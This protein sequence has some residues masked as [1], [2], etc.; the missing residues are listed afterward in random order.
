VHLLSRRRRYG[1]SVLR[2][3]A[4]VA[5]Y[6]APLIENVQLVERLALGVATQ[7]RRRI[8]RDLHD[9]TV[10]PYIG[11][12]LGLEALRRRLPAGS[13]VASE[14]DELVR[15]AGDGISHLREYVDSL[16]QPGTK[17]GPKPLVEAI[18]EQV[19]RFSE[20]HKIEV[21]L[22]AEED[23][24]VPASLRDELVNVVREALSNVRRHTLASRACVALRR[25]AQDIFLQIANDGA[26]EATSFQ[27]RSIAE[28][29]AELG[30]RVAVSFQA[31][32][33]TLVSVQVP[34]R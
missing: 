14:V 31:P 29:V 15:M 12:K 9:S 3:L 6:A 5:G 33:Q 24:S 17:G 8:S 30:G 32:S 28:R 10:Q 11:L 2:L 20:F 25:E 1:K 22:A 26:T 34:L 19:G 13:A 4:R 27:P 21:T 18:R 7:E 23:F 16:S